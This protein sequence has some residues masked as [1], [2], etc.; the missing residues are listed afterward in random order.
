MAIS[1]FLLC[2]LIVPFDEESFVWD[3]I[4]ALKGLINAEITGA[5]RTKRRNAP[6]HVPHDPLCWRR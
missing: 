2:G 3:R 5:E 6:V 1:P 4:L